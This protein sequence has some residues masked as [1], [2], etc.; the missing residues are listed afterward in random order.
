MTSRRRQKLTRQKPFSPDVNITTEGQRYLGSYIGT[1]EGQDK[2]VKKEVEKWAAEI[3]SLAEIANSE[4]QLAYTAYTVGV[5]KRWSYLMRT[6]PGISDQLGP[7]EDSIL[8]RL[9]PSMTGQPV[10]NERLRSVF[11]LPA[12]FGGLGIQNPVATLVTKDMGKVA[13]IS[14]GVALCAAQNPRLELIVASASDTSK[15]SVRCLRYQRFYNKVIQ[16]YLGPKILSSMVRATSVTQGSVYIY[17]SIYL[18]IYLMIRF[19]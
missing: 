2:F 6:T 9:I 11:S 16:L 14:H 5:S 8:H 15:Q 18:S 10:I 17:L 4:P 12:R 7:I 3:T 1:K 19:P 13:R